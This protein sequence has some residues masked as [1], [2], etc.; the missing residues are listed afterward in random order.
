MPADYM[1]QILK[2]IEKHLYDPVTAEDII[3]PLFLSRRQVYRDFYD[4]TGYTVHEYIRGRRVSNALALI[5]AWEK[6]LAEIAYLCGFSSQQALC[7][8]VKKATGMTPLNYRR[9]SD[10]YGFPPYFQSRSRITVTGEQIPA[11]RCLYFYHSQMQDIERRA[12]EAFLQNVPGYTGRLFGRDG[13]QQG[14]RFCY[15]LYVTEAFPLPN[16]LERIFISGGMCPERRGKFACT[17]VENQ[18][19]AICRAWDELYHTWLTASMFRHTGEG[20]FEEYLQQQGVPS[21]I[22]LYVPVERKAHLTKICVEKTEMPLHYLCATVHGPQGEREAAGRLAD[23]LQ[24]N[25]PYTLANTKEVYVQQLPL[26]YTCGIRIE[27]AYHPEKDSG[28]YCYE[29]PPG[30]YAVLHG[31]SGQFAQTAVIMEQWVG[32]MGMVFQA[33]LLFMLYANRPGDTSFKA[34]YPLHMAQVDN[35][36]AAAAW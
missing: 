35:T 12:V 8:E 29:V 32:S 22:R 28:V 20:Y 1:E 23:Y 14:S 33:S 25:H 30:D 9:S 4:R 24:K 36:A 5:K 17:T 31:E 16:T 2:E 6:P 18:E 34:C 7:R 10:Y 19:E 13:K 21:R 3:R 11:A 15:E 26:K 27:A